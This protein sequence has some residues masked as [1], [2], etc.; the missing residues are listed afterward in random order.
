[1]STEPE[2]HNE[3]TQ[4][5]LLS[6]CDDPDNEIIWLKIKVKKPLSCSERNILCVNK[7]LIVCLYRG[8][9]VGQVVL[10]GNAQQFI[11]W[12]LKATEGTRSSFLLQ[13]R[14]VWTSV[15]EESNSRAGGQREDQ[16]GEKSE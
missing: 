5:S 4:T 13:L 11:L 16:L 15:H 7:S 8:D 10:A 6:A 1:M 3:D 2:I 14:C 9:A 12:Q